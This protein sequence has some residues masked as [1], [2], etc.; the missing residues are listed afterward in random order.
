MNDHDLVIGYKA[1]DESPYVRRLISFSY[2]MIAKLLLDFDLIDPMSGFVMGQKKIFEKIKSSS[3]YKFVLQILSSKINVK[4]IPIIFSTRKLGK[5]HV[6]LL[7]GF[8]TLETILKLWI[9]HLS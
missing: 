7:T 9:V 5:S 4:E 1:I 8:R 6:T 2:R 3:D